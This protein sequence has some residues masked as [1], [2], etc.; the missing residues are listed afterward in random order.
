MRN[1]GIL[2]LSIFVV[3]C[4]TTKVINNDSKIAEQSAEINKLI[5][6]YLVVTGSKANQDK[7]INL[8]ADQMKKGFENS[9]NKILARQSFKNSRDKSNAILIMNKTIDSFFNR[10]KTELRE[11]MPYSEIEK[12]IYTPI[13]AELFSAEELK[14][15]ISFYRS[16]IGKKRTD[17]NCLTAYGSV[18]W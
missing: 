2:I 10:Y 9:I 11:L 8:M 14:S 12:N 5:H 18:S 6:E 3:S 17:S 7:M 15:I 16:P 1:I 13:L 4:A